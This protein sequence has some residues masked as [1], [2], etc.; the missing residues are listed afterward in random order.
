ML[1]PTIRA[2]VAFAGLSPLVGCLTPKATDA[3]K[4]MSMVGGVG[5][6][7]EKFLAPTESTPILLELA[8]DLERNGFTPDAITKLEMARQ[9]DPKLRM[10]HKLAVLYD[11]VGNERKALAEFEEALKQNPKDADLLNDFGYCH[12][13]RGRWTEAETKYRAALAIK[14]DHARAQ[15]NLGLTLA[16]Q[17]RL[18]EAEAVF[19][20]V[21]RPAEAK[22]NIAFVLA[23]QGK[24][25]EARA[26]YHAALRLESTLV[27]ARQGLLSLDKAKGEP[28]PEVVK[29]G[30]KK[31]LPAPSKTFSV[32]E[33][34][35]DMSP[36]VVGPSR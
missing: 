31:P 6:G 1:R 18:D 10:N 2:A 12:Y 19:Q 20:K 27:T 32:K 34:E 23:A 25:E 36:V 5:E 22:A 11:Q 30:A 14:P 4:P 13:N 3:L 35:P 7:K 9:L 15:S 17:G 8:A 33:P 16:Q 29:A 26:M 21:V 24:K 28:P